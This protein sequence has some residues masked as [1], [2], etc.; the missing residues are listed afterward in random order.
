MLAEPPGPQRGCQVIN[1]R[2]A[3]SVLRSQPPHLT[4]LWWQERHLKMWEILVASTGRAKGSKWSGDVST[5]QIWA[6]VCSKHVLSDEACWPIFTQCLSNRLILPQQPQALRNNNED[7][8]WSHR[9][10]LRANCVLLV[11]T[12]CRHVCVY[13]CVCVRE[14]VCVYGCEWAQVWAYIW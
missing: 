1:V 7:K 9:H 10:P 14:R 5:Q 12:V 3:R 2:I 13:V 4:R 8:H 11:L 6:F